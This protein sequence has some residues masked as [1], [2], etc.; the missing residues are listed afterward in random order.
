MAHII[1]KLTQETLEGIGEELRFNEK[2]LILKDVGTDG[3]SNFGIY[4][5][6]M[7]VPDSRIVL[8]PNPCV[9]PS[10]G[11]FIEQGP[12]VIGGVKQEFSVFRVP[13]DEEI[14]DEDA[15]EGEAAGDVDDGDDSEDT[16][17]E[18]A[19]AEGDDEGGS[20]PASD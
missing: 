6:K 7:L 3:S 1:M 18:E 13:D 16:E 11:D 17:K 15:T 19:H 8:L 12:L 5:R 2:S 10:N 14:D 9:A 4:D 20:P